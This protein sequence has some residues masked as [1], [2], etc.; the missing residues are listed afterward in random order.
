[1]MFD[2]SSFRPPA[3]AAKAKE[4]QGPRT[5][6]LTTLSKGSAEPEQQLNTPGAKSSLT[7]LSKLIEEQAK[8]GCL[9]LDNPIDE[10]QPRMTS[11]TATI[12]TDPTPA[13]I[14][15]WCQRI[16]SE[17]SADERYRRA[18]YPGGETR[19][20]WVVPHRRGHGPEP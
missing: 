13:E 16:Q 20:E 3:L 9:M 6:L 10:Q 11:M 19:W 17:W 4:K 5:D 18:N 15:Q 1:M 14:Q 7:T 8:S 12:K 2:T